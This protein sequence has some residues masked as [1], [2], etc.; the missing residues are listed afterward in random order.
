MGTL[1]RFLEI[2][3]QLSPVALAALDQPVP[4]LVAA[5]LVVAWISNPGGAS[6]RRRLRGS[7]S[8]RP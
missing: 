8:P 5:V 2:L 3:A 4:A 1:V 6:R 7:A